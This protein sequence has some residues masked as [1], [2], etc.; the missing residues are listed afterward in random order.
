MDTNDIRAAQIAQQHE[1]LRSM[2]G[3]YLTWYTFFWTINVAALAWIVAAEKRP[4]SPLIGCLV[5]SVFAFMN[6]LGSITSFSMISAV[7]DTSKWI[8]DATQA[9][10]NSLSSAPTASSQPPS[11]LGSIL[12]VLSSLLPKPYRPARTTTSPTPPA[13]VQ[14]ASVDPYPKNFVKYALRANGVSTLALVLMWGYLACFSLLH[15]NEP[16]P[17]LKVELLT[18]TPASTQPAVTI[19]PPVRSP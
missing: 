18:N 8:N 4:P 17:A 7:L 3:S 16:A 19:R 13:P 14:I 6:I 15:N 5:A 9:L 2:I 1:H 12:H 10:H 11:T